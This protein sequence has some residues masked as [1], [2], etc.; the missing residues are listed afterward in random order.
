MNWGA[1]EELHMSTD[2]VFARNIGR[3][4]AFDERDH[5]DGLEPYSTI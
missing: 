2:D 4:H 1:G 5:M 3:Y